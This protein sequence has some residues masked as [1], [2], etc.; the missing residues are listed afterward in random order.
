MENREHGWQQ[1]AKH[2]WRHGRYVLMEIST[3]LVRRISLRF[4]MAAVAC[5]R[6]LSTSAHCQDWIP[7]RPTTDAEAI[8]TE[9]CMD[10]NVT[11]HAHVNGKND[12][13]CRW[14]T[15]LPGEHTQAYPF[16]IHWSANENIYFPTP[17]HNTGSTHYIV[18]VGCDQQLR[19]DK[20]TWQFPPQWCQLRQW[21]FYVKKTGNDYNDGTSWMNAFC[22]RGACHHDHPRFA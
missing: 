9:V 11:L 12:D 8:P 19:S 1:S 13:S 16:R 21:Q 5:F 17:V 22:Q 14:F 15:I 7:F 4:T 10:Y 18:A 3:N 2:W 6:I 20:E